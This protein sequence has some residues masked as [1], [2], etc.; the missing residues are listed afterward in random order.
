MAANTRFATAVHVLVLLASNPDSLKTSSVMAEQ[1]QTN[2]VVIRRI[3]S[4]LQQADLIT[5]QKGPAGGSRPTHSAKDISLADIY[6]AVDAGNALHIPVAR[7]GGVVRINASLERV[8]AEGRDCFLEALEGT[9]LAQLLKRS[10]LAVKNQAVKN[11]PAK[12]KSG[13]K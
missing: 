12:N 1:L 9:T 8:Y 2:A 7:G 11:R 4:L 3:L 10:N 5:S 6:R 13:K